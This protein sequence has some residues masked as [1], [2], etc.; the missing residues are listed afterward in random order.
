[1]RLLLVED[2]PEVGPMLVS[3]LQNEG[4][5][6]DVVREGADGLWLAGEQPYDA[7]L[8]DV[9]L[10]DTDG[11]A[12]CRELREAGNST[13]VLMLTGRGS[14]GD[15]VAGL[16]SGADDYLAKPFALPEL[17]ARLR[18]LAR[19]ADRQVTVRLDVEGVVVDPSARSVTR[20]G[21][22]VPLVGREYAL[23]ELLARHGGR[24]VHRDTI[25]AKLWDF[26]VEVSS[27]ALDV[28]VSSV[29][30]KLDR[31]FGSPVLHTVRGVGY[32]LG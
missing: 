5:V 9:G 11:F 6:V 16:D 1:M 23:V 4:N 22:V 21:E 8:L 32:R 2:D 26:D 3:A 31:P 30:N 7:I 14:V 15:R 17:H 28:L 29:R 19:R 25:M 10:P 13:P 27:N 24:I 12:V 18:A 20:D